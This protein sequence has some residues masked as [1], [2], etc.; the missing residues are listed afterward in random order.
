MSEFRKYKD[1]IELNQKHQRE[2]FRCYMK[3]KSEGRIIDG[4]IIPEECRK[5]FNHVPYK[6]D[7]G[8]V[9]K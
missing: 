9:E 3:L 1:N 8:E 6:N 5:R 2:N 7:Y 4:Y